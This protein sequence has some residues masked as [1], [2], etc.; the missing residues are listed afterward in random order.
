VEWYLESL[1]N[2]HDWQIATV[3]KHY[4]GD[5]AMMMGSWGLRPGQLE[6][7]IEADLADDGRTEVQRGFD[8]GRYI[9]GVR[10]PHYIVY[11]TWIDAPRGDCD[12][13]GQDTARWSPV[14]HLAWWARKNPLQ[15]R[16]W[17]ENTGRGDIE[18]MKL[19]CERARENGLGAVVWAFEADLFGGKYASLADYRRLIEQYER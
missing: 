3:R 19:T 2:Y 9:A 12:D 14:K 13:N 16:V 5:V 10:D 15:L 6:K 1:K 7:L 8:F 18:R 11:S 4:S 17:G